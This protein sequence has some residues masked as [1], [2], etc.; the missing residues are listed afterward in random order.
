MVSQSD[1]S[2][3]SVESGWLRKGERHETKTTAGILF[4]H[5]IVNSH[6]HKIESD[7]NT[8][9]TQIA[10]ALAPDRSGTFAATVT[11]LSSYMTAKKESERYAF[12][13]DR[14]KPGDHR[15]VSI[16]LHDCSWAMGLSE[17]SAQSLRSYAAATF[18]PKLVNAKAAG[19]KVWDA[20]SAG[21]KNFVSSYKSRSPA[22]VPTKAELTLAA[23]R[24]G[25]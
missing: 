23:L 18:E 11:G 10:A 12:A 19:L 6:M 9:D 14:I 8:L 3:G 24:R 21:G 7:P 16:L 15:T 5:R 20:C 4:H 1:G 2:A 17:D 13:A 25:S 22:T